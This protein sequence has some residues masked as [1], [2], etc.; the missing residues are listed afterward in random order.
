MPYPHKRPIWLYVALLLLVARP[1]LPAHQAPAKPAP[2]NL[3]GK[4]A[5]TLE[6]EYGTSTPTL[7]LKQDG[8]KLTGTYTGRY[9]DFPIAGTLTKRAIAFTFKMGD[10]ES[11]VMSFSGEVAE[12]FASMKGIADMGEVG[13]ANKW[14]A[15]R[16]KDIDK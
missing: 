1:S 2:L 3:T 6:T 14:S 4:W 11:M 12:D 7:Q 8:E 13:Q 9:G 15:T 5:M 10:D 16:A